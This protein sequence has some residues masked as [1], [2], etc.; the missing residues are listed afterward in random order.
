MSADAT[1]APIIGKSRAKPAS[2]RP[3]GRQ[4]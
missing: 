1:A 3:K 4:D 2:L